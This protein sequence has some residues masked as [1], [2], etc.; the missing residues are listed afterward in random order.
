MKLAVALHGG[1]RASGAELAAD[2]LRTAHTAHDE[3]YSAVVA[4]QHFLTGP[5]AYLQPLPLLSRLIPETGEMQLVAGVLLLP[6][7]HPVQLAEELAT[8]DAMSGGRLVVGAGQGYRDVEFAAFGAPWKSRLQ[9]Q[10][11]A[12]DS[13][14]AWWSGAAVGDTDATLAMRPM[15]EPH[16][17]VWYAAGNRRAFGR[18]V[19]RGFTPFIGPQ[20][21]PSRIADLLSQAPRPGRVALRR[22][23]LVTDVTGRDAAD[24][25]VRERTALYG[26]WGYG[27]GAA[28]PGEHPYLVGTAEELRGQMQELSAMG[29]TDLVIR[30][31]WPGISNDASREMLTAVARSAP[32]PSP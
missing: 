12:L 1:T 22:D 15:N 21:P 23:V 25:A 30:T 27:S 5:R 29:I 19:D 9:A 14:I 6:L 3:G 28:G 8:I 16:P 26:E 32:S 2:A 24:R 31:N 7:L 13:M 18:A 4:G 20:A 11:Q 10:L 17:P